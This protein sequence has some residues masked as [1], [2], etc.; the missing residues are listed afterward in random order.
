MRLFIA[1]KPSLGREIAKGLGGGESKNGYIEICN[2]TDIVTWE[3]GHLLENYSPED[4]DEKFQFR[5]LEDLPIIPSEWKLKL[6][7]SAKAQ[8]NTIKKLASKADIIVNAGDPDREGQLLVDELLD[9]IGNN[10]PVQRILLNALDEKSV[11]Q[12]LNNLRDNHDFVGLKNSARARS[13]ADW[14]VGMNLS[15]AFTVP[16]KAAGYIGSLRIGRVKTPTMALVVRREE[17][18]KNF[19]PVQY[20][21]VQV[22]WNYADESIRSIWQPDENIVG[23]DLDERLVDKQV[24]ID[25]LSKI[26]NAK[27]PAA[28]SKIEETEKK[29]VQRLPYS[30]SALQ[31]DAGKRYGYDPKTVLQC[32]QQLYEKKLTTYPRSDCDFLPENQYSDA[33]N[34]L[35]NLKSISGLS[36][37]CD[38]T[39]LSIRTRAWNDKKISA[40][41]AIIPTCAKCD[42]D[43]LNEQEQNLY[44]MVA[45]AYIAQF[46]PVH[47]YQST[48]LWIEC[49]KESFIANG[50]VIKQNGWKDVYAND[51]DTTKET[52]SDI[53]KERALPDICEGETVSY[54]T[55]RVLDKQTKPPT[56]FTPATLLKAMKEIHKYVKDD[57]LKARLKSVS[58]IGTEATRASIIDALCTS[59]L[60]RL[61]KKFLIPT[62]Q[63][64]M[65]MKFLPDTIT[66]P[67]TTALWEDELEDVKDNRLSIDGFLS[68]KLE[69]IQH[70]VNEAKFIHI[71][72]SKDLVK[73]PKCGKVLLRRKGKNGFFWGCSGY[74]DC[75]TTFPDKKGKPDLEDHTAPCP[76]CKTG[77]L[78]Q[79]KGKYGLFWAC[80]N[81][82]CRKTFPDKRGKPDIETS[83]IKCPACQSGTLRRLKGKYGFFWG[84]NNS[85]CRKIYHDS[86]GKPE[87]K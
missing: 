67:D 83:N 65:M 61:E 25:L 63:A 13:Y 41:H 32:M 69:S 79:L 62:D 85:E 78:R 23:L 18:I 74:P 49:M 81:A 10:K 11:K 71:E 17:E 54:K 15:R 31:V 50:K 38:N 57:T 82:D 19:K 43:S 20:Y 34:V 5:R 37:L 70:C 60:L 12:A 72:P 59:N 77:K 68:T 48:K 16:A 56:R 52:D 44:F 22:D 76:I 80:N 27:S 9:Y 64:Y 35:N 28:I 36:S 39:D 46:Y 40:H 86:N 4:Y 14:L 42:F 47:I 29:E 87:L 1:E 24:G 30:L 58:G 33:T 51:L 55:G 45:Q 2:S 7:D 8:F 73:C 21:Q 66:W 84:C 6:K 75:K 53:D 26:Q 3:F